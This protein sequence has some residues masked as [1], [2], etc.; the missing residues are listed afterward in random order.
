MLLLLAC[1]AAPVPRGSS[2]GPHCPLDDATFAGARDAWERAAAFHRG[3]GSLAI[4]Q[5]IFDH[6][7]LPLFNEALDNVMAHLPSTVRPN[8]VA[9]GANDG[10]AHPHARARDKLVQC[11]DAESGSTPPR[12]AGRTCFFD[13]VGPIGPACRAGNMTS[14]GEGDEEK[15]FCMPSAEPAAPGR[16]AAG[17]AAAAAH[18]PRVLFSIGSNDQWDFELAAVR[19]GAFDRI[20]VFDC[21]LPGDGLPRKMP[22]SLEGHVAFHA[23]CL[24]PEAHTE[25]VKDVAAGT[26][27]RVRRY[28]TYETLVGLANETTPPELVKMDIEGWE[29]KMLDALTGGAP[30]LR[31]RQLAFELHALT[32]APARRIAPSDFWRAK[33][34]GEVAA[35]MA[36]LFER[37]YL[38][39]DRRDHPWCPHCTELVVADVCARGHAGHA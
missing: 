16:G 6:G 35:L 36:M 28:E 5:A 10:T 34:P 15:R 4:Q 33:T 17:R 23:A 37:G 7:T 29:W 25:A 26:Q 30:R 8:A 18:A 22:A 9:R 12:H 27:A 21:T 31:P 19:G 38:L 13:V 11:W 14:F 20:H 32:W 2:G 24:A 1:L 3:G 39:I